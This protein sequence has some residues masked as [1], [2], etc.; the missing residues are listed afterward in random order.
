MSNR[1]ADLFLGATYPLQ[2]LNMLRQHPQLRGYVIMPIVLNLLVGITLY[3]SLLGLGFR[4]IDALITDLPQ[5]TAHLSP[6]QLPDWHI[7]LPT[8]S[9]PSWV[10]LPQWQLPQWQLPQLP[11]WQLSLPSWLTDWTTRLPNWRNWHWQLPNWTANLP[12]WGLGF[13]LGLLRLGLTIVLLLVT[14]FVF[15]QFG[16]LLGAPWYGKLSEE[17]ERIKTGQVTTIDVGLPRDISR[18]ILYE[19]KKLVTTLGIGVFLLLMNGFIGVGTAIASVGGIALA[20]TIVCLDFFDSTLER[21]RLRFREKLGMVRATLPASA[22]FGL[23]CLALVSVP[24]INLL[25]VPVCV[26][27]GTLFACDRLLPQLPADRSGQQ[28]LPNGTAPK[29]P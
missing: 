15:L 6:A 21:R 5:W 7:D 19:L 26:M 14:G 24:L 8:V 23:V 3:A 1:F 12:D 20:A 2:A 29:L 17:I 27:A 22:S 13:L 10:A 18:A 4:A 16:G 25:A 28:T 9:L 11:Q